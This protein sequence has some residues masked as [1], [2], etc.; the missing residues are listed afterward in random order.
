MV[1]AAFL[2]FTEY[3]GATWLFQWWVMDGITDSDWDVCDTSAA[4]SNICPCKIGVMTGSPKIRVTR[5]IYC[6][7]YTLAPRYNWIAGLKESVVTAAVAAYIYNQL[8]FW[9]LDG[10]C[11]LMGVGVGG[12]V[13][14][15]GNLTTT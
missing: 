8:F 15:V 3:T 5:Y 2:P 6:N 14:Y 10:V 7:G 1:L 13:V 11:A 4:W 12:E 9:V